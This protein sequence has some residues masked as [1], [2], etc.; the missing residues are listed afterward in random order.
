MPNETLVRT[1]AEQLG[2]NI[3]GFDKRS[4]PFT[5]IRTFFDE[6]TKESEVEEVNGTALILEMADQVAQM[7]GNKTAA[8]KRAVKVAESAAARHNY[9]ENIKESNLVNYY[10][11]KD[12]ACISVCKILEYSE[13]FRQGINASVSS[14]HI[15]VEIY[16]KDPEILNALKWS[17][18]LDKVF[19]ENYEEDKEILWQY[20]GSQ[21]G[22]MRSFPASKW[23]QTGEVD[24]YDVRR[25]PWYT[26]GSSS[27][28]DMLILIDTS[29]S[30]VGQSLQLMKVAV[31][32]ILDT[33]GENDFVQIVQFAKE[34]V[35]VGCMKR[36]VQAN[37][38]NKKY[39]S[40]VVSEMKAEEMA[41]I[42]KG[43]E[44][45]FDQFDQFENSTEAG[46][47]AHC[48]KM[49]M[50][51]TDGSTD[52][53]DEVF[54]RRNFNRPLK[55]RVRVFT[56]AVGQNP[57]PVKDLK[58]MACANRGYFSEIPAMG[59]IRARVQAYLS[60]LAIDRLEVTGGDDYL[61]YRLLKDPRV[62]IRNDPSTGW[63]IV[64]NT[65]LQPIL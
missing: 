10:K 48:N 2:R 15:P 53:G 7:L 22:F 30:V 62:N 60:Y 12:D 28:K 4:L 59:A 11:S 17:H 32:S 27:P 55:N 25:R 57:N 21:T 51:L 61:Q 14:V 58:W 52:N 37:Y 65:G 46:V 64:I 19:R 40:R 31:K 6:S 41:N 39:L 63:N 47:G 26:Q 16:D 29:G 45:A 44:Y 33:L 42:S 35:T 56:Y 50:L 38:R 54:K 34:A 43:L 13:K 3:A 36:F 49:I 24:L 8:L 1:W 23:R 9:S 5:T 18:E 20:F